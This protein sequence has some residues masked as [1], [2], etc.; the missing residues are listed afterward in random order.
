LQTD[1]DELALRL[2][3]EDPRYLFPIVER[4]QAMFDLKADWTVIGDVLKR[5]IFL[6]PLIEHTPGIRVPGCWDGFELAVRSILGQQASVASANMM[7]ASLAK[8]FG[9]AVEFGSRLT[10]LFP[11]PENLADAGLV[12]IGLGKSHAAAI[13]ELARAVCAKEINFERVSD[14]QLLLERLL[15]IRGIGNWMA[16]YVAMRVLRDPDAFPSGDFRLRRALNLKTAADLERRSESWR[17]WRAYAAMYL[18]NMPSE[19]LGDSI[20]RV[21]GGERPWPGNRGDLTLLPLGR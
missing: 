4:V 5:D 10:H 2:Q 8:R 13:R 12:E 19:E 14:P 20:A 18:W 11:C 9:R 15:A 17:P 6:R 16:Q 3:W 7:A 1:S 21:S